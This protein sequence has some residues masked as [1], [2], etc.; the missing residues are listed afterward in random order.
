MGQSLN[1]PS[2]KVLAY[3]A[4]Q[5]D[6][7]E[8]ARKLGITTLTK[9]ASFYGLSIVLGGGEVRLLDMVSSYGVFGAEG[10]K[11]PPVSILKIE[12]SQ[13][14]IVEENKKTPKRILEKEV[15]RLINDIL[16]DNQA[17]APMFGSNSLMY[18]KDYDVA[19]KTGTTDNYKDAWII[20]Y[21]PS[22]AAGVWVG[23]NDNT[24]MEKQPGIVL[25]GPIWRE[26]MNNVLLKV[27][28]ENFIPLE[29]NE[30]G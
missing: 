6:S 3:L 26:F 24:S 18:F 4:G 8:T 30:S 1:V 9:P 19:S 20:G 14:N 16:S 27:P 29:I 25:A 11:M 28:K 10:L 5:K 23:N 21:T 15:A 2:V 12:D 17:R 7:I 22:I 13:G